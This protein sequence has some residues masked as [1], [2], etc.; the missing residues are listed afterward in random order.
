MSVKTLRNGQQKT[1]ALILKLFFNEQTKIF[2]KNIPSAKGKS[3]F[4]FFVFLF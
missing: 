1:R 3:L 4:S 2:R